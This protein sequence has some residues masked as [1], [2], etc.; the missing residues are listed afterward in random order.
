MRSGSPVADRKISVDESSI[1]AGKRDFGYSVAV[2]FTKVSWLKVVID[3]SNHYGELPRFR[4]PCRTMLIFG[5]RCRCCYQM[6]NQSKRGA[7]GREILD[8]VSLATSHRIW[9]ASR[10]S[11]QETD[12]F[13]SLSCIEVVPKYPPN[14]RG[15]RL[16]MIKPFFSFSTPRFL[17]THSG[18][19]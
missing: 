12:S 14:R 2:S 16:L 10:R 18:D 17:N 9:S 6:R 19:A 7:S 4:T 15:T 11:G 8:R 1:W 3:S 5:S 13:L